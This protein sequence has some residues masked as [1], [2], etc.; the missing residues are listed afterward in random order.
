MPLPPAPRDRARNAST[1][2]ARY[3]QSRVRDPRRRA[4]S[5]VAEV[6]GVEER[7]IDLN[8]AVRAQPRSRV[9][10]WAWRPS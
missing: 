7:L 1:A 6:C 10:A 3:I 2:R 4:T 5:G 8:S 9:R